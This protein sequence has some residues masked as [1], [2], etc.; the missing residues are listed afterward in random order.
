MAFRNPPDEVVRDILASPKRIAVVGCSPDAGRDSH[1]IAKLLL[2]RGHDVVPVNPQSSAV[3]GRTCY[4][5]LR[6]VPGPVDMVDVFRRSEHVAEIVDDAIAI[7]AK[8]VWT[9]LGVG[10]EAAAAKAE[11]AGLTVVM[12]RCPAIEYRRLFR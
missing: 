9:Q 12:D 1:R 6:D 5:S 11:A 2:E 7:G 3:L 10:D 8:I 4:P